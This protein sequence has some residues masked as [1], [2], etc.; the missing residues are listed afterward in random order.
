VATPKREWFD[1]AIYHV[2]SRGSNRQAIF[3]N[4]GDYAEFE[5][6]FFAAAE[7][8]RLDG[9]GWSFM[10]N[11]WHGL[12]RCPP[13][14]L[15]RFM[16]QLHQRYALRFDRRW[17]RTAHVFA[18]H[19]GAVLQETEA[20][21][22]WTLRYVV[23]NP[24][25]AGLCASPFDARWTSFP[26]TAGRARAP[27]FLRVSEILSHFASDPIEARRKYVDFVV[28]PEASEKRYYDGSQLSGSAL[29]AA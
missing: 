29:F 12:L 22:L 13:A 15:S 10:P 8:H 3:L 7:K 4:D 28:A 11:H 2:Y 20:Q 9:F 24:V 17:G 14:G 23:R 25:E 6:L 18:A 5:G 16:Q 27:G 19:F 26:A 1:G 21:F